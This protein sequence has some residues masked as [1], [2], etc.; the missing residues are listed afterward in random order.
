MTTRE[1]TG[2][3]A[4]TLCVTL[5]A[6]VSLGAVG[7]SAGLWVDAGGLGSTPPGPLAVLRQLVWQ[8]EWTRLIE[9]GD[10]LS[11]SGDGATTRG[12]LTPRTAYLL[13]FH[14]AQDAGHVGRMLVAAERLA[15]IGEPELAENARQVAVAAGTLQPE[16]P[17]I[18]RVPD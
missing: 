6:L 10:A 13:A 16:R 7:L 8:D 17:A 5:L 11:A 2:S 18:G 4:R 15:R 1:T 12:G 3:H 9:A 14:E